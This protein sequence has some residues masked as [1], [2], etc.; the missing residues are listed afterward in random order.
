MSER[1]STKKPW[2]FADHAESSKTKMEREM[3]D[4]SKPEQIESQFKKPYLY[5]N[6][7]LSEMI[8]SPAGGGGVIPT[9]PHQGPIAY[10]CEP[11]GDA[12]GGGPSICEAG[13]SCGQWIFRCAHKFAS[14]SAIGGVIK[15]ITYDVFGN[16]IITVCW[17]ESSI[18]GNNGHLVV[19]GETDN[20]DQISFTLNKNECL[21]DKPNEA[22]ID[23]VTC[24][25]I[26][27]GITGWTNLMYFSGTQNIV[28]AGGGGGPYR[29]QII[30]G[31][32][33]LSKSFTYGGE[34]NVYTA[35]ASNVDCLA[36]PT[37]RI[38]DWCGHYKDIKIA[39]TN[40]GIATSVGAYHKSYYST[41]GGCA[42]LGYHSYNCFDNPATGQSF[43]V[44]TGCSN[45]NCPPVICV[46]EYTWDCVVGCTEAQLKTDCQDNDAGGCYTNAYGNLCVNG[47]YDTRDAYYKALGCCP[48]GLL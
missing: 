39:I 35:P 3:F 26:P 36:N 27:P 43:T 38:T 10:D 23:C 4:P 48:A 37:I 16:I 41:S 47:D 1:Y 15:S 21:G 32:G 28:A 42:N 34:A 29:W 33:S 11:G 19:T 13:L 45:K 40:S 31:G 17:D 18:N 5:G 6:H 8:Y 14:F 25:N 20:G 46:S 2:L 24:E 7:P 9:P 30:S 22:C 12:V 44:C